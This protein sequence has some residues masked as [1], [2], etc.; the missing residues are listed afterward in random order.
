MEKAAVREMVVQKVSKELY[1]EEQFVLD[2]MDAMEKE[3]G[4]EL[5]GRDTIAEV[6]ARIL[7]IMDDTDENWE[8]DKSGLTDK[9]VKTV[10]R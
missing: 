1:L 4:D 7:D 3:L 8:S 10:N 9:G 5:Y 2:V 6:V